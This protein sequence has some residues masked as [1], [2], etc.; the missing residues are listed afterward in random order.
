MNQGATS[1]L[2]KRDPPR[3]DRPTLLGSAA[4][5]PTTLVIAGSYGTWQFT[6]RVGKLGMNDGARIKIA[7]RWAS[8]WGLPQFAKPNEP[9]YVTAETNGIAKLRLSF[10]PK[11]YVRPWQK[12]IVV[13]VYDGYLC[14]GETLTVFLGDTSQG[15]PGSRAQTFCE[16]HF[17]F[18]LFVDC[19]GTGNFVELPLESIRITSGETHALKV[20]A[21]SACTVGDSVRV[22]IKAEDVWGN[23]SDRYR[24]SVELTAALPIEGL[25][26]SVAFGDGDGGAVWI[27]G[28]T[29]S[30]P[31]I[32][33][34]EAI[35]RER[36]LRAQSNPFRCHERRPV[37]LPFWG[38]L[39]GQ[40][41]EDIGTG[42]LDNF[43]TFARDK[44]PLDFVS[45]QPNDFN[46]TDEAWKRMQAITRAFYEPERFVPLL[47][48]EW[49][50]TSAAGGDH[51]LIYFDEAAALHRSSRWQIGD[52]CENGEDRV[53][54]GELF[55]EIKGKNV[56]AIPHVGG[57]RAPMSLIDTQVVPLVEIYS[58]WGSFEWVIDNVLE[59]GY[60]VGFVANSDGH[61][62][63]PGAEHP[64]AS[65][66]F[67]VRGG[68][69]CVYAARLTREAL[70]DALRSRRTYATTGERMLMW[71]ESD[72]HEIGSEYATAHPPR[73]S[74]A[75]TGTAD[76]ET[77]L[78]TR[79]TQ[80]VRELRASGDAASDVIRITWGG[81]RGIDRNKTTVWDGKLA[82][83]NA[84][85]RGIR[86]YS[87]DTPV[88]AV[89]QENRNTVAWR[90]TT[91]GDFDGVEVKIEA[92]SD[93]V[94]H[95]TSAPLSFEIALKDIT[96]D[97][98]IRDAGGIRQQVRL[99]R[100][101]RCSLGRTVRMDHV[102]DSVKPGWNAYYLKAV[103][104][105]GNMGWTS[106]IYVFFQPA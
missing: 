16:E 15:S 8:D 78:L 55:D 5:S 53:T 82:V 99:Q 2:P 23:P 74:V 48:M 45:H 88:K 76:L 54:V 40:S 67:G 95:F 7:R 65:D 34:V 85:V 62:G 21:P 63:R 9:E 105:D 77:V 35:D 37:F 89:F 31:G 20:I 29:P 58:C 60:R 33:V 43:F 104:T 46:V 32:Y 71:V 101:P 25:P 75:I 84:E 106:P 24:G 22:L 70:R 14:E 17:R 26:R 94:L 61:S 51:N 83:S 19:L 59:R 41:E 11:G 18:R 57:R 13:D 1:L 64:G 27:E 50:G 12:T 79:G 3:Y 100:L 96:S 28:L 92:Q 91:V 103:Q 47:G 49:S 73:L 93:S 102:D 97:P 38:D 56:I 36:G 66:H 10:D 98:I 69:T 30:K 86:P 80:V 6:Y 72:G 4:I 87:I 68:L 81:A 52:A 90:S 39:Q 42:P 44:A